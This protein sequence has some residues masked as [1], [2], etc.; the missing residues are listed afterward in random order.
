MH[1]YRRALA[2]YRDDLGRVVLSLVLIAVMIA[3]GI[4]GPVPLAIFFNS[5]D[6]QAAPDSFVYRLFDWVPGS[7]PAMVAA[8]ALA[9]LALKLLNEFIRTWQTQL[10]ILIGYR[11]RTRVQLDLFQKL[12]GLSLKYHKTQP[13]GDAI[14]RLSYD[15]HGFQGVLNV[16]TGALINVL[17]IVVMLAIM[18]TMNWMLTLVALAVVPLLYLTIKYWGTRLRTYNDAQGVA[19]AAVTTQV[20]RSLQSVGLV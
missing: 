12:Q 19:D 15:T 5:F 17:T 14:Y 20:Q 10:N 2:Y 8:L 16:V 9:M 7:G 3:A 18:V 11:G 6:D 13:Q 1:L 4:V